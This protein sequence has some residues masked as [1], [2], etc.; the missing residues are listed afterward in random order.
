MSRERFTYKVNNFADF[1]EPL[2]EVAVSESSGLRRVVRLHR[3]LRKSG[4][5]GSSNHT[6]TITVNER[7]V[8]LEGPRTTGLK[9]KQAAIAQGVAISLDFVLSEELN[10]RRTKIVGDNDEVTIHPNQRFLCV[11]PDDN[12]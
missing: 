8:S 9:I 2:W 6:V 1:R 4:F 10:D 3:A 7:L 11:A 12:S 5:M